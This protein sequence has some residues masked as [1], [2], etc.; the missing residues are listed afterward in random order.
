M[1]LLSMSWILLISSILVVFFRQPVC[2]GAMLGPPEPPT[3]LFVFIGGFIAF[4]LAGLYAAY[5][6]AFSH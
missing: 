3:F 1:V 6:V 5:R 4:C 2:P